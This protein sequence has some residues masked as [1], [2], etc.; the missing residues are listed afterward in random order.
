MHA[1]NLAAARRVKLAGGGAVLGSWWSIGP[2]YLTLLG[3]AMLA[4][5]ASTVV[6]GSRGAAVSQRRT[7]GAASAQRSFASVPLPARAAVSS[8]L[9]AIDPAYRIHTGDGALTASNASQRLGARFGRG[10]VTF[11]AG[12]SS[13]GIRLAR[14]GYGRSAVAIAPVAPRA[15]RNSVRYAYAGVDESLTNGPL[16]LEQAFDVARPPAMRA[17]GVLTLSLAL[18]GDL[19]AS[20]AGDRQSVLF[21]APGHTA[22]AYRG[23][24]VSDARGRR[25]SSGL[26]LRGGL[27]L[28]RADTRG[29]AYPIH[30]DPYVQK[31]KLTGEASAEA[32][33][34]LAFS[35]ANVVAGAPDAT[36]GG[37]DDA[38][39]VLVFT[40]APSGWSGSASVSVLTAS[41]PALGAKLGNS[42]AISP[43]GGTIAAGAPGG[44]DGDGTVFV[45]AEN[46]NAWSSENQVARLIDSSPSTLEG[47]GSSVAVSNDGSSIA[48]GAIGG[49]GGD[50]AVL[51]FDQPG[52]G[53]SGE[54]N[55][56]TKLT[57]SG[58]ASGDELGDAVAMSQDGDIVVAGAPDTTENGDS[59]QGAVYVFTDSSGTWSSATLT[60]SDGAVGAK[61]GSSVAL[62]S[63]TIVAGAPGFSGSDDVLAQGAAFVFTEP[64]S[65]WTSENQTAK[66]AA[67]NPNVDGLLGTSVAIS[68]T[69]IVAGAPGATV[70]NNSLQGAAY[71]FIE[72]GAA[73]ATETDQAEL[74][75]T[76]GAADDTLG[77]S[78]AISGSTIAAGAP[79]ATA[80]GD[81]DQGAVYVFVQQGSTSTSV[82]C[83]PNPVA[84]G[85]ATSCTATVYDDSGDPSPPSGTV[86]F[87]TSGA[88]SFSNSGACSLT[89]ILKSDSESTCSVS[90]TENDDASPT[91]T[92]VYDGDA[93]HPGSRSSTT[94]SVTTPLDTTETAVSCSNTSPSANTQISCTATVTDATNS[95]STPTG[96]VTWSSTGGAGS[97]KNTSCSLSSGS[98][99]VDFTPSTTSETNIV[100]TY[101]GDST[102]SGSS[103]SQALNGG[104]FTWLFQGSFCPTPVEVGQTE[105]C[106]ADLME[107]PEYTNTPG[108]TITFASSGAA[109]WSSDPGGAGGEV[110]TGNPCQLTVYSGNVGQVACVE[111]Y[112]PTAAGTQVITLSYSGDSTYAPSTV[113]FP[114]TVTPNS[115]SMV[116]SCSANPASSDQQ[117]TCSATVTDTGANPLTPTGTV[118]FGSSDSGN[119]SDDGLCTLSGSAG[120]SSC[121]VTYSQTDAGSPSITAT[122]NPDGAHTGSSGST[123]LTINANPTTTAVA[124]KPGNPEVRVQTACT[125]TVTDTGTDVSTPTGTVA[126]TSSDQNGTF[127]DGGS[128]TL[129]TTSEDSATCS[130]SYSQPDGGAPAIVATYG[131]DDA[132]A[133][134]PGTETLAVG[135]DQSDTVVA[136]DPSTPAI[137]E[138]TTCTATVTDPDASPSTPTGTVSF[139]S[140]EP[141]GA[142]TGAGS[143]TLFGSG[144]EA[145]CT[146][147]YSQPG[148]GS[149]TISASYGGDDAHISSSGMVALTVPPNP[150]TMTLMCNESTT[151]MIATC[152]A[153]VTDGGP[154]PV[155]PTGSI[156]FTSSDTTGN[157]TGN[158]CTLAG[159]APF[160]A[161]TVRYSD[162]AGGKVTLTAG[163]AGD[164]DHA[165]A[166]ASVKV[167]I[168]GPPS[169]VSSVLPTVSGSTAQVSLT[170]SAGSS[171]CPVSLTLT[172]IET[173]IGKQI[174]AITAA[175]RETKKVVVIGSEQVTVGAG[176][177]KTVKIALSKTGT[178][179][180]DRFHSLRAKLVISE[181]GKTERTATL[182]FKVKPRP[183]SRR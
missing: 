170:C 113:A 182:K 34:S 98:C 74:T 88:G 45:F 52:G 107:P 9:G 123:A 56:T 141:T 130:L 33:Y 78:I 92:A 55:Q 140:T 138:H 121:S 93:D 122:Y 153:S 174:V 68:G 164:H 13:L 69:T 46:G 156:T 105:T 32:G 120:T 147:G 50:G 62:N 110:F 131:G 124:C 165:A 119:F 155:T 150:T 75:A 127:T 67:S 66:L 157:F 70:G 35:G 108:G 175:A 10:G 87:S 36:V 148:A 6:L 149:P 104:L 101:G 14:V 15:E 38:G 136:C 22:I 25:L 19:H 37:D 183:R 65:A 72:P 172:A 4:P 126:F 142:F 28:I 20:L 161:C 177:H 64:G 106:V 17:G 143:C 53:W 134:S 109:N 91:I 89:G 7:L 166:S 30:V 181:D 111:N 3:C 152:K 137:G 58:G 132:H 47:L 160:A 8:A 80:N 173:L 154:N 11:E 1:T 178:R 176:E 163:Y 2:A 82:S 60:L 43:D 112:T 146:V 151:G 59:D 114:V 118:S 133:G 128:C 44:S 90:Y 100:A 18:S 167:L 116:V 162:S 48:A 81:T 117:S 96:T 23:L 135:S 79:T 39:A 57:A 99:A 169:K 16:G 51:V 21:T 61:L 83:S 168:S 31:A 144:G 139:T 129:S 102:H 159:T 24:Y 76:D 180:L 95:S 12:D 171:G 84:S 29:A 158:P 179:L 71:V 49:D 40:K 97:F 86:S 54:T 103:G 85:S 115:T 5:L 125:A 41:A 26:E 63:S 145:T 27:L 42:V 77:R 94:L 73:W